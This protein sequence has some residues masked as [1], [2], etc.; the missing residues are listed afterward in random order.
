MKMYGAFSD[1][2][3]RTEWEEGLEEAEV[4]EENETHNTKITYLKYK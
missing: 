2:K 1:I 4:K 3:L